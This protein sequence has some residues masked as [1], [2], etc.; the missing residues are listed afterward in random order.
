MSAVPLAT[1]ALVGNPNVG[2]STLFNA[3]SGLRQHVGNYPGVTV[4]LMKG[5]CTL[6]ERPCE[7]IDLPG[8]YSLA[9][10]SPDELVCVDFLLGRMPNARTPDAV[11]CIVDASNL[12]RN[13]Y[14][15]QQVMDL[16]LPMVLAVNMI[17]V[18]AKQ[19]I[20]IDFAQLEKQTG[21]PVVPIQANSGI[22]FAALQETLAKTIGVPVV[23]QP[24]PL[25]AAVQDEVALLQKQLSSNQVVPQFLVLRALMDVG[26]AA[27]SWL[28]KNTMPDATTQLVEARARL[29]AGGF[30]VPLVEVKARYGWIRERLKTIVSRP[31]TPVVTTSDRLDRILTHKVYGTLIFLFIMFVVFQ[32]IFVGAEPLMNLIDDATAWCASVV[33]TIIPEGPLQSLVSEGIVSGVGGIIKFLP[34]ILLLFAFIAILE[35]CGYMARAAFLMDKIMY[36]CGLSGKSFIPLLSSVACAVPGIMATRVIENRRDRLATILVAPLMSCSARLPVYSMFI[37]AF[38]ANRGTLVPGLTFFGLYMI[39]FIAAPLVALVLK[40]TLLRGAPPVFLLEL[41]NYKRPSLRAIL[42]RMFQAGWAFLRRAGTLILAS[43]IL[44]WAMLYYPTTGTDGTHYPNAMTA[45]KATEQK[46]DTAEQI[47]ARDAQLNRLRAEWKR[48]SYLGKIGEGIEPALTPLGWDWKLGVAALASFPAREV[49]VGTLGILYQTGEPD[50]DEK[51]EELS[52]SIQTDWAQDPVRGKYAIPVALSVMVFFALC[53]QCSSTLAVIRRET[54][55][56]WWPVF[57]FVYMTVLAY[58]GAMLTFQIGK[59]IVNQLS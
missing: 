40:R 7:I 44:V 5:S 58:V 6:G 18:A 37:G 52:R 17:D 36:R 28:V 45:L 25:P 33:E 31:T 34:Q 2:K 19:Q 57:T 20:K 23:R 3:L 8:T 10:R 26:G 27:E 49:I 56:W 16:G 46:T 24:S 14:L 11:L 9:A 13:L 48:Q 15:V 50:S 42:R 51:V 39:G 55:S 32:S 53:C 4:D 35:D 41:P 38:L 30:G 47:A 29:A 54:R 59:L 43:M 22:G 1:I 12:E 21:I